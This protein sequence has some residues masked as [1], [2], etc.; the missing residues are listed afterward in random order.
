M[1]R[2]AALV[3]ILNILPSSSAHSQSWR[4]DNLLS[5]LKYARNDTSR[6]NCLAGLCTEYSFVDPRKSMEFAQSAQK[7][8]EKIRSPR[9]SARTQVAYGSALM[10]RKQYLE[11]EAAFTKA[12]HFAEESRQGE[13]IIRA[14]IGLGEAA[15]RLF[16]Y[17]VAMAR[18]Q[19]ALRMAEGLK[20]RHGAEEARMKIASVHYSQGHHDIATILFQQCLAASE[21]LG[22][23]SRVAAALNNLS[24]IQ[25]N[26][27]QSDS[28]QAMLDRET[29]S[30]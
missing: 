4:I 26:R 18:L 30:R 12:L 24:A 17:D 16:R 7:L 19:R 8:A 22:D 21:V 11:A 5:T 25:I 29:P 2:I 3:I 6:I 23:S 13:S 20:D 9:M 27:S 15:Q 10:S 28:A 1:L 14:L